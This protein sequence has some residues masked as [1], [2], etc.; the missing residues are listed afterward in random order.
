MVGEVVAHDADQEGTLNSQLTYTIV[1]QTPPSEAPTFSIDSTSGT[2]QALRSLQRKEQQ[3]YNLMINVSDPGNT[4][5][6]TP[7][8]MHTQTLHDEGQ[9]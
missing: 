6:H 4:H 5:T 7:T 3:L 9:P 1:S 2:I 8:H